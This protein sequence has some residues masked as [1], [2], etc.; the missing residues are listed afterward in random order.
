M[1]VFGMNGQ[2]EGIGSDVNTHN[3]KRRERRIK[4]FDQ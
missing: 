4:G 2:G 1:K 3:I